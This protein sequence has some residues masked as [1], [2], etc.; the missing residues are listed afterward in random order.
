MKNLEVELTSVQS[1]AISAFGYMPVTKSLLIVYKP[2]P[3]ILYVYENVPEKIVYEF[4]KAESL[5][6]YLAQEIKPKFQVHK[7]I[8]EE[9]NQ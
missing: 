9:K 1:T 5:G 8:I 3:K 6:R 4:S 7:E 2:E